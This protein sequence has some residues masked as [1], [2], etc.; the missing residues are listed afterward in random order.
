[1]SKQAGN[2]GDTVFCNRIPWAAIAVAISA[3]FERRALD[4]GD[5]Q[6]DLHLHA[7]LDRV[8]DLYVELGSH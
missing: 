2:S 4:M 3:I 7:H 5:H 8:Q 1:M 6:Y